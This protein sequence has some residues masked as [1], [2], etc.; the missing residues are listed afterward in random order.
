MLYTLGS[1]GL[2]GTVVSIALFCQRLVLVRKVAKKANDTTTL[3]ESNTP[4]NTTLTGTEVQGESEGVNSYRNQSYLKQDAD[5]AEATTGGEKQYTEETQVIIN[6]KGQTIHVGTIPDGG[7]TIPD[8]GGTIPDGGE[9]IPDGG[10][11]IPDG[12]ETIPDG[13]GTIPDGGGTIPDGG[14]TI[15]DGGGTIPDGGGTIPDGGGT[16]PDGGGTI[17]DGGGTIPDGGGTIPD[18]GETTPNGGQ[19]VQ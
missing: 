16:I 3:L 12:G 1:L 9:T 2:L 14:G 10:G 18:G 17:P 6:G 11:T 5:K 7:G 8:G 4:D 19:A 13:G 15:P